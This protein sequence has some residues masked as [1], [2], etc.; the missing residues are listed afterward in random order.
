MP[1]E[2]SEWWTEPADEASSQMLRLQ[3]DNLEMRFRTI[4]SAP[5]N[6]SGTLS[7]IYDA[8]TRTFAARSPDPA[9]RI[10]PVELTWEDAF[11]LESEI[12][13][14]H[15]GERLRQE[16]V[17]RLR[18][19][20]LDRVPEAADLQARYADL[21]KAYADKSDADDIFRDF[22]LEVLESIHWR[23][24][25]KHIARKLR[26]QAT[27]R[28]LFFG[29][30]ALLA[31]LIPWFLVSAGL[32]APG[33]TA[34]IASLLPTDVLPVGLFGQEGG[35]AHFALYTAVMFGFMGAIFS[36]LVTLQRQW[37]VMPLDELYS[38]RTRSY[39]FLRATIGTLGALV[40]Y[41][42]LQSGLVKGSVFPDFD[43]ISLNMKAL[44]SGQGI[45]WPSALLLPS[46]GMALLI[47]WSFIAGF[48][49]TL[50]SNILDNT[51]RQFGA[52]VG[53]RQ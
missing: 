17:S 15:A 53:P 23:S 19:A 44:D 8:V 31:V 40:V 41:F 37:D 28:T 48:S 52:A 21:L 24:R 5:P 45:R 4:P 36:R 25:R 42:F 30:L 13:T 22:Q 6:A 47:M 14:L 50:V 38:A 35:G 11:R 12:A 49:E 33:K 39:I 18:W 10:E 3:L 27:R 34:Q 43:N 2:R 1:D 29:M 51:Q 9:A 46:S 26:S 7:K 32:G 20:A 16:I